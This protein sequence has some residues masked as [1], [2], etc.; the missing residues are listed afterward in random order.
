MDKIGLYKGKE[1]SE[2][3]RDELLDFAT[4]AGKE[5]CRLQGIESVT[6]D[7]RIKKEIVDKF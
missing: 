2:M 7:Y 4:W 6:E 5:I 1:I 3:T